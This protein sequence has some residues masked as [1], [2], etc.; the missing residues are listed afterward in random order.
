MLRRGLLSLWALALWAQPELL[1]VMSFN[2]RYP[3]KTDGPNVWENRR[4][5]LVE[6]IRL[7]DPDLIGAQELYYEQGQYIAAQLPQYVWFGVSRRG[8]R[9]DE[10]MGVFYKPEKFRLSDSGN[11]WLSE[12]PEQP[13]SMSWNVNLP[14]MVTWGLFE[15]RAGGRRFYFFNT[16]FPHRREDAEARL[17]CAALLAERLEKLPKDIPLILTGDFNSP[18][19][20]EVYQVFARLLEDSWKA[21]ARRQGPEGT[22]SGF[23]GLTAGARIDWILYR[24]GLKALEAETVTHNREGRY[25]SDH[26]PVVAVLEWR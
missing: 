2:V 15:Q 16:H 23:K 6:T 18:A 8:N 5:L 10:H 25:P 20:G 26:Y 17:K 14:R 11:F 9:E 21:A 1:R 3:A 24:G 12:T 13:G 7:K 22:I 19:G 4:D